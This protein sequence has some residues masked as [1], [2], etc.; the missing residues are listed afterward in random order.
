MLS[1][2]IE[3]LNVRAAR[4]GIFLLPPLDSARLIAHVVMANCKETSY[5]RHLSQ[6][7]K[8]VLSI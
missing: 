2:R 8:F 3:V 7:F 4:G 6:N 1:E 5:K